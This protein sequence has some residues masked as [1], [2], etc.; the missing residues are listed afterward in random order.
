METKDQRDK[1][2]TMENQEWTDQLDQE[3]SKVVMDL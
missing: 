1:L 2:E 3:V